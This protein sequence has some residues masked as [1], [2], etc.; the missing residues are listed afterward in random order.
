MRFWLNVMEASFIY[1]SVFERDFGLVFAGNEIDLLVFTI[2]EKK[3]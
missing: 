2:V 1:A 3:F